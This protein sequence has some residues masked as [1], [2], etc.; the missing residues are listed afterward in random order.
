ML[1]GA[2]ST[3]SGLP[4]RPWGLASRGQRP[5]VT[6]AR[7]TMAGSDREGGG[8][9][10]LGRAGGGRAHEAHLKL[11][12]HPADP[13]PLLADDVPVKVKGHL[14]LNGDGNQGLRGAAG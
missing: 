10:S 11:V 5:P 14:H 8:S 1:T 2:R 6:L 12:H 13:A 7:D 3:G 9:L 4:A